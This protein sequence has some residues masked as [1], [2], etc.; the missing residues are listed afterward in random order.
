MRFERNSKTIVTRGLVFRLLRIIPQLPTLTNRMFDDYDT[1]LVGLVRQ[2]IN[3]H[4]GLVVVSLKDS[5]HCSHQKSWGAIFLNAYVNQGDEI[6]CKRNQTL[7][8]RLQPLNQSF[9]G[10]R[11]SI[12]DSMRERFTC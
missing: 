3:L 8:G 4:A 9:A 5:V 6:E 10:V 1:R 2:H 11:I 12:N 7:L